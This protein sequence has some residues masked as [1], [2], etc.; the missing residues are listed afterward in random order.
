MRHGSSECDGGGALAVLLVSSKFGFY[1]GLSIG[2]VIVIVVVA[3]VAVILMFASRIGEQAEA[4]A[5]VLEEIRSD[6]AVLPH[7]KETNE[8]ALA[9]L[10][11]ART[12]RGALTG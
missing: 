3:V 2:F 12:A 1:L 7:A 10:N 8:H 4:A 11:G 5:G 9:I 6:T